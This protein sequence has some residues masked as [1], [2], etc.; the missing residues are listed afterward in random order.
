MS[1]SNHRNKDSENNDGSSNS[2][3]SLATSVYDMHHRASSSSPTK[4]HPQLIEVNVLPA[5]DGPPKKKAA[6]TSSPGINNLLLMVCTQ[7]N[8]DI[9]EMWLNE[10]NSYHL[11]NSHVRPFAL[12]DESMFNKI[13]EVYH[14]EDSS[15]RT[16]R[17]SLSVCKWARKTNKVL[18]I[19]EQQTPKLAQALKYSISGVQLATAVPIY[20]EGVYATIIYFTIMEPFAPGAKDCL[21]ETSQEIVSM[22]KLSR[23]RSVSK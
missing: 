9:A 1:H 22:A 11:I 23:R 12:N 20:H 15:E 16:H 14:G 4:N 17:L 13:L 6:Y 7:L 18:W 5:K 8:F 10:G 21:M 3:E 2:D 19:T